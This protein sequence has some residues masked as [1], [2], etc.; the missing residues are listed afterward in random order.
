MIVTFC[1]HSIFQKTREFERIFLAYLDKIIGENDAQ[2]Y[3]GNYGAFDSF[4]YDCCKKYQESHR[5]ISLV[6]VTPYLDNNNLEIQRMRYNSIIYPEIERVPPKFAI[7]H[8]N[9]YMID[10]CDYVIS[11]ITHSWGGAY[12]T[13]KYAKTKNKIIFNLDEL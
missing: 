13:Y 8:R 7:S 10:K 6:F 9:R 12:Q 4:A 3:L 1:G 5:K 2:M 11:Y